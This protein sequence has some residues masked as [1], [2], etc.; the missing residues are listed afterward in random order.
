VLAQGGN[1]GFICRM[2][3]KNTGIG[4]TTT[5]Q[6]ILDVGNNEVRID[7]SG[8]LLVGDAT[9]GYVNAGTSRMTVRGM[10]W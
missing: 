5:T 8:N 2:F 7:T 9:R 4:G 6:G 1:A 3:I 10:R